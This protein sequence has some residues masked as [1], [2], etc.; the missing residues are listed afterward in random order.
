[1]S[2]V[3][4]G[5]LRDIPHPTLNDVIKSNTYSAIKLLKTVGEFA[6]KVAALKEQLA[7]QLLYVV[8]SF[9]KKNSEMK[10]DRS[11]LSS[12]FSCW[13][14]LLGEY[15]KQAQDMLKV[16]SSLVRQVNTATFEEVVKKKAATKKIFSFRDSGENQIE[17]ADEVLQKCHKEYSDACSKLAKL[18]ST[19][20]E[21][22]KQEH[23]QTLCH[24][25]HNAYVLQLN[26]VNNMNGVFYSTTLLQMLNDLQDV[27][28]DVSESLRVA[29]GDCSEIEKENIVDSV[30]R[31]ESI[32]SMFQLMN[33]KADI[34]TFVQA[35]NPGAYTS[36]VKSFHKPEESQLLNV[37]DNKLYLVNVTEPVLKRKYIALQKKLRNLDTSIKKDQEAVKSLKQLQDSYSEN[38]SYGN[39]AEVEEDL[40]KQKNDLRVKEWHCCIAK[41]QTKLF[42]ADVLNRLEVTEDDLQDETISDDESVT[43]TVDKRQSVVSTKGKKIRKAGQHQFEDHT[44]RKPK[45]CHYCKGLIK[46]LIRQG[47]RCKA[48]KM[49]VHHKCRDNVPYCPGDRFSK[50]QSLRIQRNQEVDSDDPVYSDV[51]DSPTPPPHKRALG[52]S[53][54]LPAYRGGH[55]FYDAVE[56][57]IPSSGTKCCVAL[58]DFDGENDGDLKLC[59][60]DKVQVINSADENWWEGTNKSQ[61]GFFPA[62]YVQVISP[63]AVILRCLFDFSGQEGDELTIQANQ[64]VVQVRNEG[65]G[66]IVGRTGSVEGAFPASYVEELSNNGQD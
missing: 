63:D 44:F 58:Y 46:G 12:A 22:A 50:G 34:S 52:P 25:T 4:E 42:T 19:G 15:E 14:T 6:H 16:S 49:S 48:C 2:T 33:S 43:G 10:K 35:N 66:W 47:V 32:Q 57:T 59:A 1:M 26:S 61:T 38:P 54:S 23:V 27:Q 21:A 60:G 40:L 24:N 39:A 9:R 29:F 8:E 62:S 37:I 56:A 31:L 3:R 64:I 30:Q 36:P 51:D 20:A 55:D 65:N 41:E 13:E 28:E 7:H 53:A 18:Q 5:Y 11:A 17:K 45:F